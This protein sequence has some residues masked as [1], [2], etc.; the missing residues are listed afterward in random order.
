MNDWNL[1][2]PDITRAL[3]TGYPDTPDFGRACPWCDGDIGDVAYEIDG[4]WVCVECFKE[5]V[6]DEMSVS[7]EL[8]AHDLKVDTRRIAC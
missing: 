5:W 7:P 8:I 6:I 3:K 2:H 4:E 1:E